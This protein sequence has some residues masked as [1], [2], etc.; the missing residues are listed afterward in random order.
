M[1]KIF[2][3]CGA[4]FSAALLV[5][6]ASGNAGSSSRASSSVTGAVSSRPTVISQDDGIR[7]LEQTLGTKD[8]ETGFPLS[9]GYESTVTIDGT[10]YYN[11]R[12]SWLVDGDHMSYLTNYLVS[13][14]GTVIKEYVPETSSADAELESAATALL[15]SMADGD[16][17][18]L[19]QWADTDGV[20]FTPYSTVN[21][22]SDRRLTPEE[23]A[24][25]GTDPAVYTWGSYDGSGEAIRM[26]CREYWDQ[27]VWNANYT[28]APDVTVRGSVQQGNSPENADTAY[29]YAAG[30]QEG[31]CSYVEYHFPGLDHQYDGADWCSLKLVFVRRSG[32]WKLTGLIHSQMTV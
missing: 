12:M 20:T 11:Y 19:S 22:A 13:A 29:P 26:T 27:F 28:T 4:V 14:D 24:V 7:L 15:A 17:T 10:D 8:K 6:C 30:L 23:I 31:S 32:A 3:L 9:Y 1:R 5:S 25:I 18:A 16:F 21:F 2:L